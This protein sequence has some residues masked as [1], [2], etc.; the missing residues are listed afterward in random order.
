MPF[1]FGDVVL[2]P[3]PFTSQRASK[4]RPAVVVTNR[5][6]TT[7]RPDLIVMAVTSQLRAE[8]RAGRCMDRPLAG[9]RA[10]QT[11]RCPRTEYNGDVRSDYAS[12]SGLVKL[13][14]ILSGRQEKA[15]AHCARRAIALVFSDINSIMIACV[16]S[17]GIILCRASTRSF[18]S[19]SL[20]YS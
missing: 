3:F 12:H 1:D 9:R 5:T 7:T 8:S 13:V 20:W 17:S 16:K 4:K 2:V 6:Y 10:A 11:L 15:R 18:F 14:E 19:W